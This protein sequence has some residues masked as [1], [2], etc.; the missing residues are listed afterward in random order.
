MPSATA[1]QA[2]PSGA[3]IIPV[4]PGGEYVQ[5][6]RDERDAALQA[7]EEMRDLF[8][9]MGAPDP[10]RTEE[11]E[12]S[13]AAAIVA[14][15]N[16]AACRSTGRHNWYR[17]YPGMRLRCQDCRTTYEAWASARLSASGAMLDVLAPILAVIRQSAAEV[18]AAPDHAL[19][20][21]AVS[22]MA[23]KRVLAGL[24]AVAGTLDGAGA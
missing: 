17:A 14:S 2:P 16:A 4:R 24:A 11:L 15:I 13:G 6:L 22:G 9:A 18:A 21:F 23:L 8:R 3:A 1:T 5:A 12:A 10:Y 7:L 20:P 19:Y